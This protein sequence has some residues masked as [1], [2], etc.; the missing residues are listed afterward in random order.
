MAVLDWEPYDGLG[1]S[2]TTNGKRDAWVGCNSE[3]MNS[4]DRVG[5]WLPLNGLR[6]ATIFFF[7]FVMLD[8]VRAIRYREQS[9]VLV[10]DETVP[11]RCVSYDTQLVRGL[12]Q[13]ACDPLFGRSD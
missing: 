1:T 13:L 6:E 12:F 3:G 7:C 2:M 9:V 10:K 4:G 8:Y 5:L 11:T